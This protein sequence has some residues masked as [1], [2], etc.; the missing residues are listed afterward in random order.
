MDDFDFVII[1]G[2]IHGAGVAQAAAAAGYSVCVLEQASGL[3]TGTS[4]RSSKLIH[5]GLRY[6]ESGQFSLVHECLRERAILLQIAPELVRLKPFH[7]PVY[8]NTSRR[9][10]QL[11]AGLGLYA[12]LSGFARSGH[13]QK[14]PRSTWQDLDGLTN[15]GLQA[16]FRYY[17]AQTDDARLTE[18][19]M[20]S[21]VEL[22]AVLQL[23]TQVDSVRLGTPSLVTTVNGQ[24][25]VQ[26]QARVIVNATG[27]WVNQVI[28]R[29]A[30]SVPRLPIEWIQGTHI[31][32]TGQLTRG[33]YYLEAPRDRR[34]VF[35][36]PWRDHIMVGTTEVPFHGN[37][38]DVRPTSTEQEYLL[39][40]LGYY[41]PAFAGY[42]RDDI[43]NSFAGLRVLPSGKGRAF[44]RS[45][46]T[47]FLFDDDARP[48]FA[49]IYGGKLT[50]YRATAERLLTTLIRT[51]PKRK[52]LAD[53]RYL[54][55]PQPSR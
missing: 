32:V 30:P 3:A 38:A 52:R 37:P 34:A 28:D 20:A 15:N 53:T 29:V 26:L 36:L 7:I 50:A 5:G 45:R 14:L 41:F 35:A 55:L 17:D 51:L 49:S 24:Q 18:A 8:A 23:S 42:H 40:T 47:R 21:A 39:E 19:V 27:P 54:R 12:L 33:C 43:R 4:S 2:G 1:G 44:S 46:E 9:P 10:W 11:R 48:R 22:G 25:Q 16:V 31:E 13:Y 6:L